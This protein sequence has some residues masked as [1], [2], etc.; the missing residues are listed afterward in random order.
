MVSVAL[1]LD[2]SFA[3]LPSILGRDILFHGELRFDPAAGRVFF[4]P[5]KEDI[6]G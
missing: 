5:P 2:E 1:L 3:G 4:D 6:R